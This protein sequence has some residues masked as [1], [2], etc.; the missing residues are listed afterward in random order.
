MLSKKVKHDTYLTWCAWLMVVNSFL[1]Q[2]SSFQFFSV[3]KPL[4][5]HRRFCVFGVA[6]FT[7]VPLPLPLAT[8][9][10]V[11][12]PRLLGDFRPMAVAVVEKKLTFE[13]PADVASTR[14]TST[15]PT[16]RR[17]FWTPKTNGVRVQPKMN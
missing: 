9:R 2:L 4:P 12:G 7:Q 6:H 5:K 14:K 13:N 1:H 11:S 16:K 3:R 15:L 17:C 8:T 10:S